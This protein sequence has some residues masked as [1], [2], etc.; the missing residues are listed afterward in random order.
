M[1]DPMQISPDFS[2]EHQTCS[3][4]CWASPSLGCLKSLFLSPSSA[5]SDLLQ[6]SLEFINGMTMHAVVQVRNLGVVK[7]SLPPPSLCK[8][9]SLAAAHHSASSLCS[10]FPGHLSFHWAVCALL[11]QSCN[12]CSCPYAADTQHSHSDTACAS[13][14]GRPRPDYLSKY[15]ACS[16]SFLLF[17]IL[18]NLNYLKIILSLITGITSARYSISIVLYF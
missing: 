14:R 4:V 7:T 8:W 16:T 10:L 13:E 18:N 3:T 2:S 1:C 15:I 12:L 17:G 5:P 11:L 9:P 6:F